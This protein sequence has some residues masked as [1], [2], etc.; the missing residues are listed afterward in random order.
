MDGGA[1]RLVVER[2]VAT[3][4]RDAQHHAGVGEA[5]DGLG[6]LPHDIRVL[7]GAEVQA[8][9]YRHGDGTGSGHVAVCL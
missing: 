3:G 9:G 2:D 8:V 6:Q 5:T 7:G 4:D 1:A